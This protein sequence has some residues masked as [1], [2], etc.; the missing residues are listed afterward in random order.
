MNYFDSD[1]FIHIVHYGIMMEKTIIYISVCGQ[2]RT[3]FI[4]PNSSRR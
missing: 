1:M 2:C 3:Q 4:L